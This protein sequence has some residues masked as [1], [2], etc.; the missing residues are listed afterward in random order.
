MTS[1]N[2]LPTPGESVGATLIRRPMDSLSSRISDTLSRHMAVRFSLLGGLLFLLLVPQGFVILVPMMALHYAWASRRRAR[3]PFRVPESW[4]GTDYGAPKVGTKDGFE[5]A[6]GILYLGQDQRTGQELW[7]TNGDARRHGFFIGTTGSGKAL[8]WDTPILTERGWVLNADIRPG[9]RL[10]HPS[11]GITEVVSVHPQGRIPAVRMWVEDGRMADC[12]LDHLWQV[13]GRL[14]PQPG[15]ADATRVM[16]ARDIAILLGVHGEAVELRIP[17]SAP[18]EGEYP[19]A[20][21]TPDYL[22]Q[23]LREGVSSLSLCPSRIGSAEARRAFLAKFLA[24]HGAQV[25][26]E[27]EGLRIAGLSE[28]C[29]ARLKQTFWSLGGRATSWRKS[30]GTG[31]SWEVTAAAPGLEAHIEGLTP[32]EAKGLRIIAVEA[33]P[34]AVEMSCLKTNRPDGLYVMADYL[35]T[36]NTELLLGVVS[37]TLSWSSGFIFIDGKGTREFYARVWTLA[38]RF[39]REDDVRVLNFSDA[40]GDPDAPAGGLGAQSNTLNPFSKGSSDQLMNIVAGLM[41]ESEKGNDMWKGR[42]MSLV[43]AAMKALVEMR[44]RGDILLD[45]QAIREFVVLGRGFEKSLL[46]NAKINSVADVPAEAWAELE[47]RP[48]MIELYMRS[49]NGEFSNATR[50]AIKAYF[51][52]LPGFSME[53]ALNGEPQGDKANEQHNFLTM[54]LTKPLGALADDLGHI[55]RTPLGEVDMTDVVL[56]RRI[57][58]V[59]LPALKKARE[60]HQ[61]SG[62]IIIQLVK[63]MMGDASGYEVEGTKKEIV[64]AA[65]TN[66][67]SPYIVVMDEVGYYMVTGIDVSMAMARS[68]GFMIIVAGQDMAAMQSVS[69]QIA[70]TAIANASI[71]AV[72]KTVDGDKTV[73]FINR[74][75]GKTQVAVSSGYTAKTGLFSTKMVDRMDV[76][77][78]EVEKVRVDELQNMEMGEFYFL[79]NGHLVRATTFYIGRDFAAYLAVNRFLK[80][81]GPLDKLPGLD[82]K[83]E[84]VYLAQYRDAVEALAG[85]LRKPVPLNRAPDDTLALAARLLNATLWAAGEASNHPQTVQEAALGALATALDEQEDPQVEIDEDAFPEH[86]L[87]ARPGWHPA[88]RA[89]EAEPVQADIDEGPDF[90]SAIA[91]AS[92]GRTPAE[93]TAGALDSMVLSQIATDRLKQHSVMREL[94]RAPS[95]EDEQAARRRNE[96]ELTLVFLDG[97]G[98]VERRLR[99]PL[100]SGKTGLEV[101]RAASDQRAV[102]L[103]PLVSDRALARTIDALDGVI[104]EREDA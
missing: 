43:T 31:H 50:L 42:A 90:A 34:E 29:A 82:Q 102:P 16:E 24:G 37:Q 25:T 49:M 7:L 13:T 11:G 91:V 4:G 80:I 77:F 95:V 83:V 85:L 97:Q 73:G 58:V 76:S 66:S 59:L 104:T 56:N 14:E 6:E 21:F 53:K 61:M 78:Q 84:I 60:E 79:F 54:Q 100:K 46:R 52:T 93:R 74:I 72:G 26:C 9:D 41:G 5:P 36:H 3:L 44:D 2:S 75:F 10:R 51:E 87:E 65:Q 27:A 35:V 57:L 45:V 103:Q 39:G 70:E 71:L 96:T 67:P 101:L 88:P 94:L 30:D 55:F 40:G 68:L 69:S 32:F 47:R 18:Q 81:R 15:S 98:E 48:G 17:L 33:L 22:S 20:L 28:G 19:D 63:M 62:R 12:S 38:K 89:P 1:R 8:P 23:A 92:R 99:E 64:E 86:V